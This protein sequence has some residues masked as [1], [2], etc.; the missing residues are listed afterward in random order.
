MLCVSCHCEL[1]A[2]YIVVCPL[3]I[4]IEMEPIGGVR[5]SMDPVPICKECNKKNDIAGGYVGRLKNVKMNVG[6]SSHWIKIK[7]KEN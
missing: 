1:S 4:V 5:R 3:F 6:D 2:G 7:T